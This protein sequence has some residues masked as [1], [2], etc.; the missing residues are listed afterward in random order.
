MK[1][2]EKTVEK[3]ANLA[4]LTFTADERKKYAAQLSKIL[5]YMKTLSKV[6]TENVKPLS[7]VQGITNVFRKDKSA[8]SLEKKEVFKNA[9]EVQGTY[10]KV[11]K[12]IKGVE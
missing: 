3:I 9:P 4:K 11:P 10:F 6:D 5:E 2:D 1:I 12:V 8:P 7:H